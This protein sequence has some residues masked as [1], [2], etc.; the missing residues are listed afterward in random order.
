MNP[1]LAALTLSAASVL[2]L[3]SCSSAR[4]V[5][6][7]GWQHPTLDAK[8]YYD[9]YQEAADDNVVLGS[10]PGTAAGSGSSEEQAPEPGLLEDNTFVDAGT[11]GF[12]NA[13][14]DPLSTFALDVDTGSFSV[15]RTLLAAGV[16]PPRA[17]IRP[18]EWVNAFDYHQ[19]APTDSDLGI[20]VDQMLAPGLSDG[21]HL[22]R[23]G[24]KAREIAADERPPVA[25]TVVVDTSGS[26]DIRER[27]GLVKS[28]LALLAE[29][30]RPADTVAVVTYEDNAR[31]VLA[32]TPVRNTEAIVQ[33]IDN[34]R[35]GGSTNLEA[36]LRL[37]YREARTAYRPDAVNAV[38]LASDGVANVGMTGPDALARMIS[39]GD[40]DGIHLVTVGYG[41]GN[42]N[43]DLMEQLADQ[44][45]GFYAY[46]DTFAESERLFV[47][48]LSSTLTPVA[49]DAKVQVDFDPAAVSSYRLIGYDN[50]ALEDDDF[51]DDSVDAGELGAGHDATALYE[52]TL[53]EGASPDAA[54]G[55]VA[56]R[57]ESVETGAIEEVYETLYAA[58]AETEPSN[59]TQLAA[60]AADFAQLLKGSALLEGREIDLGELA[61]RA[62]N[63]EAEGVDGAAEL[64]A[65]IVQA[66]TAR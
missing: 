9:D 8:S 64:H 59:E 19:P 31:P 28:S 26:M 1:R 14:T 3:S 21:T 57:W 66:Q 54:L 53:A 40:Q 22:I 56:V 5:N 33:A 2:A 65:L 41:M 49:K 7:A 61:Q 44:G 42:Y 60:T 29:Q 12:V 24:V 43:D 35:P 32:P 62:S 11:S 10:A 36:G 39:D 63:L 30:L 52:V 15:A 47:D 4:D 17:S 45:N 6:D 51:A 16:R 34:L 13:S 55:E 27:L 46:V 25:L 38:I 18:E 50:R 23:V 48:E 20:A 58:D 37:G